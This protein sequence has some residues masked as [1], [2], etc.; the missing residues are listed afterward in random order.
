MP[1]SADL[2]RSI[3]EAHRQRMPVWAHAA[4]FPALPNDVVDAGVDVSATPACW[5]YQI[6][7]PSGQL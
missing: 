3:T 4:V 6:T 1:S 7:S 2:V 5:G